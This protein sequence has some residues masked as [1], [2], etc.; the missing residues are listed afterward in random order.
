MKVVIVK[1]DTKALLDHIETNYEVQLDKGDRLFKVGLNEDLLV[2]LEQGNETIYVEPKDFQSDKFEEVELTQ[3]KYVVNIENNYFYRRAFF[4]KKR[5]S[6]CPKDID[7]E[8]Y[9]GMPV[10]YSIGSDSYAKMII[11]IIETKKGELKEILVAK[12]IDSRNHSIRRVKFDK[13]SR[14]FKGIKQK[15]GLFYFGMAEEHR[16]LS[17]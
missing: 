7:L 5:A 9:V 14:K 16:D 1:E 4:P 11:D 6:E 17:F 15:N 10:T 8:L 12:N 2:E 3:K 13:K